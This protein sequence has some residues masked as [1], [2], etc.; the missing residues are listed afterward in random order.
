[1]LY[2]P[3]GVVKICHTATLQT[4]TLPCSDLTA[5][6]PHCHTTKLPHLFFF[7][8][9]YNLS[10]WLQR[11][12]IAPTGWDRKLGRQPPTASCARRRWLMGAVKTQKVTIDDL[13]YLSFYLN[14]WAYDCY[15]YIR[16]GSKHGQNGV[17]WGPYKSLARM[18][19][20][21]MSIDIFL[22]VN[23]I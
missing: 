21:Y 14:D 12:T 22:N 6:L 3:F 10:A 16:G 8:N 18:K 1:M 4:A 19:V 23:G 17:T 13:L 11:Q 5:V 15:I 9:L 7:N 2:L 20:S